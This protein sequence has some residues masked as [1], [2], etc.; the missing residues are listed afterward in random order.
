MLDAAKWFL[1][2]ARAAGED[3]KL[4]SSSIRRIG[5][6]L[7]DIRFSN[8]PPECSLSSFS[9]KEIDIDTIVGKTLLYLE[10]YSYLVRVNSSR[11]KNSNNQRLTFQIDGILAPIWELPIYRR[12][13][14]SL[15]TDEV[16]VIFK[17][18]ADSDYVKVKNHRLSS[19]NIPFKNGT[20][21]TL[22]ED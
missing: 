20:L 3:G 7:Q 8:T 22:F 1:E 18:C 17:N 11:D 19:Y 12:G 15:T 14:L 13:V 2:D 5:E 21:P 10:Q 6:Y 4:M 16:K 9:I